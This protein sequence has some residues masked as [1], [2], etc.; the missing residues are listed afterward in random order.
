MMFPKCSYTNPSIRRTSV[1]LAKA[2]ENRLKCLCFCYGFE[3]W[4]AEE[5]TATAL[6]GLPSAC[7]L[8]RAMKYL[9]IYRHI[10]L[11]M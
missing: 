4:T 9:G 1:A 2:R 8:V 7:V 3:R 10:A 11:P 5:Q 6:D